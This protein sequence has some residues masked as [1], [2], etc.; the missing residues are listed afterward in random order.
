[1]KYKVL[2]TRISYSSM[3]FEVDAERAAEAE[4][5]ALDCAANYAFS[6]GSADYE[7]ERVSKI[8]E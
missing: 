6:E 2:V 1:M 4:D 3:E 5:K 8:E 7:V